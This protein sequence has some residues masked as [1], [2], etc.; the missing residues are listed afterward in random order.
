MEAL[1][2]HLYV[3]GGVCNLRSLYA[4]QK[5]CEVYEPDP[6]SWGAFR[7]LPLP[8]VGAASAVLEEKIYVLGG[9]CQ[10]DYSEEKY[11]DLVSGK[12]Q[13]QIA[14]KMLSNEFKKL[15]EK[16]NI[17]IGLLRDSWKCSCGRSS[18]FRNWNEHS[19]DNGRD[20]RNCAVAKENGTFESKDC[21]STFPFVCYK[22]NL[23]LIKEE[24][25]WE[26][27][28]DYCREKHEDLV[29]IR[30]LFA[31]RWVQE[32][33]KNATTDCVWL[34][35]RYSC[36]VEFWFWVSNEAMSYKNWVPGRETEDCDMSGAMEINGTNY[37]W[38]S[39][40]DETKLNFICLN[41]M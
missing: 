4:D 11:T 26:E 37:G 17:V 21:T 24:K 23:I 8:H 32:K 28:I 40:S 35:M 16:K 18:S 27:A 5:A 30:D 33:A 13:F 6:D 20:R 7:L 3:T 41:K 22:D 2:G 9:Y 29:S 31:Q 19:K 12:T 39:L 10:D 25:T 38:V 34:G 1:H 36:V 15:D 14:S